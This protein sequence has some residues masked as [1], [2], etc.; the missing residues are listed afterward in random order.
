M[1]LGKAVVV[2][3]R[4]RMDD[5]LMQG[6]RSTHSKNKLEETKTCFGDCPSS[7]GLKS[8]NRWVVAYDSVTGEYCDAVSCRKANVPGYQMLFEIKGYIVRIYESEELGALL[9]CG[10]A[11]R[12]DLDEE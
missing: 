4:A 2:M 8:T 9:K 6:E 5:G 12:I 11:E 7:N 3:E 10:K 1:F